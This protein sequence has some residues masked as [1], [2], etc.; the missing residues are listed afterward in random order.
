MSFNVVIPAQ[1]ENQYHKDG[2]LAPFGDTSL[3]EW[4]IAQCKEFAEN[5]Q[6]YISSHSKKIEEVARSESVQFLPRLENESYVQTVQTILA[7]LQSQHI[8]WTHCTTP[9]I[10]AD[11]YQNMYQQ[12]LDSQAQTLIST[13]K[14]QEFVFYRDT[15]LNFI[16]NLSTRSE[17][18]PI[19]IVSNG[20]FI[21]KRPDALQAKTFFLPDFK[22]FLLD[23]LSSIEIKDAQDYLIT[24]ELIALY[25]RKEV[26]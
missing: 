10:S 18:E 8:I 11:L 1:E 22:L 14:I 3:L 26:L 5:R 4:K 24:K 15:K 20:C 25:F 7:Q 23:N 16:D 21:F 9:F 12:F 17:L 19:Y 6:I 13:R 2:D